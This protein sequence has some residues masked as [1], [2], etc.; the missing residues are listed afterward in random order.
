[1]SQVTCFPVT[2]SGDTCVSGFRV[3]PP[4]TPITAIGDEAVDDRPEVW[5][6]VSDPINK[7]RT[8]ERYARAG[9]AVVEFENR[10]VLVASMIRSSPRVIVTDDVMIEQLA[11]ETKLF[12]CVNPNMSEIV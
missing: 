3:P 10:G 1:M 8:K 11:F 7:A 6:L 12:V 5:M 4:F 9:Y 2:S